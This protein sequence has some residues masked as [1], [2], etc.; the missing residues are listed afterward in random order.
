MVAD[1]LEAVYRAG[2]YDE[3]DQL[4][5]LFDLASFHTNPEKVLEYSDEL[6]HEAIASNSTEYIIEAYIQKGNALRLKGDLNL[7]LENLLKGFRIANE[8][9]RNHAM[10]ILFTCIADVYSG[11]DDHQN[12][13]LNY[14]NAIPILK[15]ENDSINYANVLANIGDEYNL[16]LAKPDSALLFFKE[17]GDIYRALDYKLGIAYN[18]SNVGIAYA[19]KG[20]NDIAESKIR[21]ATTILEEL[22]DY[23]PISV[24]LTFMSDIYAE[25]G[26]WET[27][28][29]YAFR[30]LD[31]A[32]QHGLKEQIGDAYLKLSELYEQRGNTTE[33]LK[34]YK[35]HVVFRDSVS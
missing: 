7:A 13:I 23:Y 30:S 2:Q 17:S 32:K 11:M 18:L 3:K 19:L 14:K 22:G 27:A 9:R 4:Q 34:Y 6:L 12:A 35:N 29:S 28:F 20:E 10:G 1:S 33:S 31:L 8:E 16:K 15:A 5:I 25:Q 21:Q 24:N 26:K